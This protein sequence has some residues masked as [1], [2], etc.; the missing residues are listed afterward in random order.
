MGLNGPPGICEDVDLD[1]ADMAIV[2]SHGPGTGQISGSIPSTFKGCP[3]WRP[4]SSAET[5]I[6]IP[7]RKQLVCLGF[8]V[9]SETLGQ[10]VDAV[11]LSMLERGDM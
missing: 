4:I 5:S 6:G 2:G 10:L 8:V 11:E 7:E 3:V 9:L 1:M